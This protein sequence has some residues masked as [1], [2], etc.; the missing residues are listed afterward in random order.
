LTFLFTDI[1][2]STHL[3][4]QHPEQMRAAMGRHAVLFES[5][6]VQQAGYVVRPRGEGDSRFAVFTRATDALRAAIAIQRLFFA[7]PWVMLP[8]RVRIAIHSG[9]ADLRDG[10]YYGKPVNRCARLRSVAHG[11]QILISQTTYYLVRDELPAG[12]GLHD[13]GEYNLKDL[14]RA[15]HIFQPVL[16]DLPADFPPL[17]T[18]DQI[19]NNLPLALT[20]FI[21]RQRE[22]EE[23]EDL[24]W[25]SRLLTVAGSGGAGKTRLAIRVAQN[26]QGS[27]PDGV[28]FI[29]LAPLS[30]S[31]LLSQ[32]VMNLLGMREE[33]G[34]SPEQSL[35]D[36]LRS[37]TSLLILDN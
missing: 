20:S 14:E 13:L 2:G 17:N 24:L 31:L 3:W 23:L 37:K 4:E 21:G 27:F 1:E 15:K 9:E 35:M 28:W 22:I 19:H 34:Y 12:V 29:D 7:E 26:V 11:G 10:D 33:A 32:Y 25:Q 16:A 5:A 36:N 8:L 6:V 18:P 30:N